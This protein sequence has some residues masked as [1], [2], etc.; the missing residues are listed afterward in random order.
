MSLNQRQLRGWRIPH[1]SIAAALGVVVY[2]GACG[3]RGGAAQNPGRPTPVNEPGPGVTPSPAGDPTTEEVIEGPART[4]VPVRP[5]QAP[6]VRIREALETDS[7]LGRRVRVAGRCTAAGTG[8]RAGS[9]TL[10]DAESKIEV[11]GLVPPS[12]GSSSTSEVTIFAQIEPQ[13]VDSKDRLLLRL[14]D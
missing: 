4:A 13:A 10:E 7:L 11:R 14:P 8:R 3:P 12:C 6:V 2:L 1:A 5:D 9:W